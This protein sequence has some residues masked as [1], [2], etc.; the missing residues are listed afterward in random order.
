MKQFTKH[1]VLVAAIILCGT[2]NVWADN[3]SYV[4]YTLDGNKPVKHT[5]EK[6]DPIPLDNSFNAI[7]SVDGTWYVVNGKVTITHRIE[8]SSHAHIILADNCELICEKGIT[9]MEACYLNIYGQSRNNGYLQ[10]TSPEPGNAG[11]GG[12]CRVQPD[13]E[14]TPNDRWNCGEVNIHGGYLDVHGSD[15][16]AGI[17]GGW[18]Q[19]SCKVTMYGGLVEAYGGQDG[20]GIGS[21]CF[22]QRYEKAYLGEDTGWTKIYGGSVIA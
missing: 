10:V 6:V 13:E 8:V 3:V 20:A 22:N 7:G 11:I 12:E 5:G 21:G 14:D 18:M 17:G 9:V 2:M 15:W 19:R 4:Y 16:S 1:F